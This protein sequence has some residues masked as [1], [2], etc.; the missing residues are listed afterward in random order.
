MY[1]KKLVGIV[2]FPVGVAC[3]LMIVFWVVMTKD[4]SH[5]AY[6]EAVVDKKIQRKGAQEGRVKGDVKLT[7]S[8]ADLVGLCSVRDGRDSKLALNAL[9]DAKIAIVAYRGRGLVGI[10]V[11]K[12][13]LDRARQ[14]LKTD[15]KEKNY[16]LYW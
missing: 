13:D 5:R 11:A 4:W 16:T 14:I 1:S 15:A 6:Q 3:L 2:C 8:E 9:R 7:E 10:S 12:R